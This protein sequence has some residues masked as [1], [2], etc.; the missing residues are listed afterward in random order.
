[1]FV[2]STIQYTEHTSE[3]DKI[4]Y[5]FIG[6]HPLHLLTSLVTAVRTNLSPNLG[7]CG[8]KELANGLSPDPFYTPT[9]MKKCD[10]AT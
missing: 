8:T 2:T 1:M 9:E 7:I 6:S 10:L 5:A 3:N 4:Q